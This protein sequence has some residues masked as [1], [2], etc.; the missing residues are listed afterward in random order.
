MKIGLIAPFAYALF[1]PDDHTASFFGG[2]EV[3]Q[4]QLAYALARDTDCTVHCI[5]GSPHRAWAISK[6][7]EGGVMAHAVFKLGHRIACI[8]TILDFLRLYWVFFRIRPD[9]V[10][11]RGGGVL[12]GKA[13]FITRVLLGKKFIFSSMHDRESNNTYWQ[14]MSAYR[15]VFFAYAMR[16]ADLIICQHK[17]QQKAFQEYFKRDAVVMPTMYPICPESEIAP[18]EAREYVLWVGRLAE[19]KQPELFID[20]ARAH[21]DER[22]VFVA[23]GD[24][25]RLAAFSWG[26]ANITIFGSVP[27][28]NI[29]R[30]FR[31][32]KIFVNTSRA[33]GFPNTFVQ[34]AK[35][36]TPIISLAVNPDGML[37]KYSIGRCAE[38][39]IQRLDKELSL[40]LHNDAVWQE[41]SR[42]GYRYAAEHHNIISIIHTYKK[43][44]LSLCA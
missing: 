9:V 40:F 27:F 15:R 5:I 23:H 29:D 39:D 24:A 36:G 26:L 35:N 6:K 8:D 4:Y 32:A 37:P 42:N 34:A 44:F 1:Y 19:W 16:H 25:S 30:Y 20:L 3:Q 7:N 2:A 33:E 21:P 11:V 10:V 14:N 17:G 12:A 28:G 43:M 22:F 31:Y 41:A 18:R 13:A 38:G